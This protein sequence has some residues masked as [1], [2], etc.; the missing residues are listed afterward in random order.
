MDAFFAAVEE[1]D[2]PDLKAKPFA[3]GGIGMISTANY[4]AR[5]YG[6]RSAMPGFIA[7]KLCPQLIFVKS[8]FDKYSKASAQ[9]RAVFRDYDPEFEAGSMDEAYLDVTEYVRLHGTTGPE[10]AALIRQRVQQETG[11]TCS[12]GIA[13]NRML[14]K[15]C[16]DRNKPNGQYELPS[17]LAAVRQFVAALEIR[18]VPGVGKVTERIL[19]AFG[20]H[21]AADLH[22]HRALLAALF[23]P[24]SLDF[25]M[26]IALGLG[27]TRHSDPG[28]DG[29][30]GRKGMSCERT[31]RNMSEPRDLE[32]KL[33]EL[34]EHL[35][36]DMASEDLKGR[37]LTLKLKCSNFELR[38]RAMTLPKYI[39]TASDI[40]AAA[41]KLLQA[42]LPIEVRLM[43]LRMSSFLEQVRD[44]GQLSLAEMLAGRRSPAAGAE[45][46]PSSAGAK[47][48]PSSAGAGDY[49][50]EAAG[51]SLGE[52]E[53]LELSLQDWGRRRGPRPP[54]EDTCPGRDGSRSPDGRE[55]K[56][57]A[58]GEWACGACTLLNPGLA[59]RCEACGQRRRPHATMA[60][61]RGQ[62]KKPK[63]EGVT[64]DRFLAGKS[65]AASRG[66][67]SPA[68]GG[69]ADIA[70]CSLCRE[71]L[72]ETQLAQHM[73]GHRLSHR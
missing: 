8:N 68:S 13:P 39:H 67:D 17:T 5:R 37:T 10:V 27:S 30:V 71:W 47:A 40:L 55:A 54:A 1:R 16:S 42:E 60:V 36:A 62:K 19:S 11:L 51:S 41:L 4:V 70:E 3:V 61:R 25:F 59:G 31:F 64:L 63:V 58:M 28:P 14:A 46:G 66:I 2:R 57:A 33:G 53:L 73:R 69:S 56:P 12:V 9:T 15:V 23:S 22:T 34:A 35:A 24:V 21:V 43:G 7:L 32:A 52:G 20:V 48:G 50:G 44:P 65:R 18:K 29:S 49:E 38:T 26:R 45:A 72:P 6:V